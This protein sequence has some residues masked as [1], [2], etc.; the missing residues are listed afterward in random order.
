M[1]IRTY[2]VTLDTKN[3]ISPEPV[4]LRQGD[5]TGA[6]VIDATLMDNGSPV[7]LSGLTPM[8]KANTADGQAVIADSTGFNIVNASGGEFT[9]QVPSQLGSVDGKI[10]I[11]YFSFSDSSGAQSTFN[12]VFVV[13]K[14]AD[15]TQESAKDWVSNLNDI[16]SQYNQWVNDAHSSWQDF[17]NENKKIIESIDPGGT[18]LTEVIDARNGKSNL[19]TR[20][21]DEHAQVTEQLQQ[22][23]QE[24]SSQLAQNEKQMINVVNVVSFGADNTGNKDSKDSFVSALNYAIANGY[25]AFYI[26]SGEYYIKAE[27]GRALNIP[28]NFTVFGDGASSII[29]FDDNP[30][31]SLNWG[32]VP[33]RSLDTV[34]ITF[35][36]FK[37]IGSLDKYP[38][39]MQTNALPLL[40]LNGCENILID[41]LHL[42]GCRTITAQ[43]GDCKNVKIINST[44]KNALR[45]GFRCVNSSNVVVDNNYF[46]N[47]A[48]DAITVSSVNSVVDHVN[49][50]TIITNNIFILS[51]GIKA[52]GGKNVVISDNI[53][54]FCHNTSISVCYIETGIEGKTVPMNLTVNNNLIQDNLRFK[55]FGEGALIIDIIGTLKKKDEYGKIAGFTVA[56]YRH[57]WDKSPVYTP[58]FENV[59]VTNNKIVRTVPPTARISEYG[60]GQIIMRDGTTPYNDLEITE[61]C[62]ETYSVQFKNCIN[63]ILFSGNIISGYNR[64]N[65]VVFTS[66]YTGISFENVLIKDN[67]FRDN[68]SSQI[69]L[70]RPVK[71]VNFV[72]DSNTFDGDPYFRNPAHKPDNTWDS[73]L[74]S[75]VSNG[76]AGNVADVIVINNHFKNCYQVF[77]SPKIT[78][79]NFAYMQTGTPNKGIAIKQTCTNIEI[80]GDPTS[81]TYMEVI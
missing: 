27:S 1:A 73:A 5:K 25:T 72:I 78:S 4:Y 46:H 58:P 18:L 40:E 20:L 75:G 45:D 31:T 6:V 29:R 57:N 24:L 66:S 22:T 16:I 9:Y 64:F 19:K 70:V 39:S 59:T 71:K 42:E 65:P 13:E 48:D 43:I 44:V 37:I 68:T 10:K 67:I 12:V 8:F 47:V 62:F 50:N 53:F 52:L 21:D 7:S 2:K 33:F 3:Y 11:A 26:P 17:V 55:Q 41:N 54:K 60:Y 69:S 80:D 32:A 38:S 63:N 28:S 74:T 79:N 81:Q 14:A 34:N 76:I 61:E 51:Q 23:E 15:M 56:P 49:H 77:G 36:D 35:K 30:N